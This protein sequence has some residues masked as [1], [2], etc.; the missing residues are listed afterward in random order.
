MIQFKIRQWAKDARGH[1]AIVF[2]LIALPILL[3]SGM[4]IDLSRQVNLKKHA[5]DAVDA[6][7]LA[8]AR[9]FKDSFVLADARA[10][11]IAAFDA[12]ELTMHGDATC[13]LNE[14]VFDRASFSAA[15]SANCTVPTL[16]GI[17]ISGQ[18][19]VAANVSSTAAAIHRTADVAM[20]FDLSDSMDSGELVSLKAAGKRAAEL[21]IGLQ[22]GATGRVAVIPFAGGVNAGD[23]GNAA[24]GRLSGNDDEVDDVE[25][26]CVTERAG[27][28]AYTDADPTSSPVGGVI[29]QADMIASTEHDIL[30]AAQCPDSPI[31]PLDSNLSDVKTAIDNM[32]RSSGI[33]GGTT[34]G[35]LGIA[36]SWYTIS[37]NW[38]SVWEDSDFGG[39]SSHGAKPYGDPNILKVAILMTDGTFTQAFA[40]GVAD[41]DNAT[42]LANIETAAENLCDGMRAEGITIYAIAYDATSEAEA[43]LRYCAGG[44][45]DHYF[46]TN[47]DDDL[48]NIYEQ[49]AGKYLNVGIVG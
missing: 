45:S 7:A 28:D 14:P 32:S 25:R 36:W 10:A 47:D 46:E 42:K 30:S 8:G 31:T 41:T 20:M 11:A 27:A 24:T 12:N 26:V 19:E 35:H 2:A 18:S 4:T 21:I 23:F 3:A 1:A 37:P 34:A 6:A 13:T 48:E 29:T 15:V 40:I 9:S 44:S 16:F 5:Q 43:L 17:G 39:D 49:I 38:N 22:P 33:V